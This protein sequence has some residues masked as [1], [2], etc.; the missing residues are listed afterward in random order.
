LVKNGDPVPESLRAYAE[1]QWQ[2]PS[3][4][5]WIGLERPSRER[6]LGPF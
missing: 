1:A 6:V 3:V 2:R 5:A 4:A